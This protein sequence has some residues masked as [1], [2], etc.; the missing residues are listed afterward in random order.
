MADKIS[1]IKQGLPVARVPT[2][3]RMG[4]CRCLHAS[5]SREDPRPG[6]I[7]PAAGGIKSGPPAL[8]F[9]FLSFPQPSWRDRTR[10]ASPAGLLKN[11]LLHSSLLKCAAYD[12]PTIR[13]IACIVRK[14]KMYWYLSPKIKMYWY[15]SFSPVPVLSDIRTRLA[16]TR[17][18]IFSAPQ[19]GRGLR[20]WGRGWGYLYATYPAVGKEYQ[21][22]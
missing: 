13:Y 2:T 15:L 5:S 1:L 20:R 16:S 9:D 17:T 12:E 7:P 4:R 8:R 22:S 19:S 18:L 21:V 6:Q 14:I 3:A 11:D 10:Q